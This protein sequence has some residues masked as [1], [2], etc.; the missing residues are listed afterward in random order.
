[1]ERIC[2]ACGKHNRIPLRHVA[3]VGRCGACKA[4]LEAPSAPIAIESEAAFRELVAAVRVPVLVD[5]WAA[6]CGPCHAAAPELEKLAASTR[7]QALVLKVDTERLPQLA[8]AFN[9]RSIPNFVVLR[10]SRVVRQEAG[11]VK[12]QVMARWLADARDA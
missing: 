7:G 10:D 4:T 3:D 5:F 6:W 11:V 12:E 9:V 1:M 2:P 8:A